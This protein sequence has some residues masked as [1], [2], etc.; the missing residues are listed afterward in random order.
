M[1]HR[2]KSS[3][4]LMRLRVWLQRPVSYP[5]GMTLN[6]WQRLQ[7]IAI[8]VVAFG[9]IGFGFSGL[10]KYGDEF[11]LPPDMVRSESPC[12]RERL[13]ALIDGGATINRRDLR[14]ARLACPARA[15]DDQ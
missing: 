7:F 13:L 14:S 8:A 2:M 1:E 5:N 4:L 12:V 10:S 15:S 11:V 3:P 6:G 9:V